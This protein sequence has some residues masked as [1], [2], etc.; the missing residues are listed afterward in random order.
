MNIVQKNK[1]TFG[2]AI[3]Y[4]KHDITSLRTGRANPALVED[5]MVEAY[6]TKQALRNVASVMVQDAKTLAV[7]PWDKSI[8]GAVESALR[9]APIGINPVNDG[10]VIRLPLPELN[11]ERR[12][13][14]LKVLNQKLETARIAIRKIREEVKDEIELAEKENSLSEDEKFS[15][16]DELDK[17]V[18]EFNDKVKLVGEEKEKEITTI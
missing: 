10:K 5:V 6:G 7:E 4:L 11:Q 1:E 3:D 16:L 15:Q 13:D 9:I 14:L 17:I 8:M 2:K 18:K 12:Q